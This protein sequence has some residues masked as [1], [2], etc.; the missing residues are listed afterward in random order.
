MSHI[1]RR[2][3]LGEW[4]VNG[5]LLATVLMLGGGLYE[6]LV[7]DPAW[8]SNPTL[9]Q[10]AHGGVSR[11]SFWIPIHGA[12]TLLLLL[13]LWACWRERRVRGL[14][15]A[16][17]GMYLAI[18]VWTFLYFIPRV[19]QFES[20]EALTGELASQ[21]RTWVFLSAFREPMVLFMIAALWIAS[22]HMHARALAARHEPGPS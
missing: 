16:A 21:A 20:A 3:R 18:R 13:S 19:I 2:T 14:L 8:P 15:L 5:A 1:S 22:R 7:V 4:M 6:H 11:V 9:V 10:A 17:T 12:T